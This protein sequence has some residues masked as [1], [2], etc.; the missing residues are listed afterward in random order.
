MRLLFD[1][2]I[3]IGALMLLRRNDLDLERA[4][5]LIRPE[6]QKQRAGQWKPF[7]RKFTLPVVR[8]IWPP[9]GPVSYAVSILNI[10]PQGR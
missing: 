3:R 4:A 6:T 7:C 9:S 2:G 1:T 5:I 8:A 10:W